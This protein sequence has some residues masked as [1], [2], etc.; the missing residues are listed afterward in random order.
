MCASIPVEG[1]DDS[2]PTTFGEAAITVACHEGSGANVE[3]ASPIYITVT[4]PLPIGMKSAA[5]ALMGLYR[6]YI[7]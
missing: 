6:V 2:G 1:G 5:R 4:T 3:V 7:N